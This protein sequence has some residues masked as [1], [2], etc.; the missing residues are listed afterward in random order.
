MLKRPIFITDHIDRLLCP[1]PLKISPYRGCEGK[2]A[3]CSMDGL[4]GHVS[5]V[6]PSSVNLL[7]GYSVGAHE[8]WR[9]T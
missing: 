3:Y 4:R 5:G 7:N 1:L 2:C 9:G 6:A 8:A